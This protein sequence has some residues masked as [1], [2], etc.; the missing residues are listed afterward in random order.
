MGF[1]D[2]LFEKKYCAICGGELGLFGHVNLSDGKLCKECKKKL[3]PY[4]APRKRPVEQIRAHLA[5][6]EENRERLRRFD[7]TRTVQLEKQQICIDLEQNLFCICTGEPTQQNNPDL[8]RL[9]RILECSVRIDESEREL[10]TTDRKGNY[11]SY[12]PPRYAY[13]RTIR[14]SIHLEEP[15]WAGTVT[16]RV[17]TFSFENRVP[18]SFEHAKQRANDARELLLSLRERTAE[19]LLPKTTVTCPFCGAPT[20]PDD[21]NR[22]E[23]CMSTL[24]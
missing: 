7:T 14:L 19:I 24:K 20:I 21:Q 18:A 2:S 15:D 3:S 17:G 12:R 8:F 13:T 11:V 9:D 1:F 16:E 5:Y 22:C 6:R 23:Y 10:K 4:F